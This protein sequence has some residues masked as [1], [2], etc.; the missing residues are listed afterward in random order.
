MYG[1][2]KTSEETEKYQWIR[3]KIVH[4][5][6]DYS[7]QISNDPWSIDMTLT[8]FDLRFDGNEMTSDY[9]YRKAAIYNNENR[10][11]VIHDCYFDEDLITDEN[12]ITI[13]FT[14]LLNQVSGIMDLTRI[15]RTNWEIILGE[16]FIEE[17]GSF[18]TSNYDAMILNHSFQ[19]VRTEGMSNSG[20][21]FTIKDYNKILVCNPDN[22]SIPVLWLKVTYS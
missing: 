15:S 10:V 19:E 13:S 7:D 8:F 12:Q 17:L 22:D 3:M 11:V 5:I 1:T 21:E 16:I 6:I 18:D 14:K 2:K 20:T 9:Q 4:E